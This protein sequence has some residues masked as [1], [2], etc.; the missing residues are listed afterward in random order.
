MTT[1]LR[2]QTPTNPRKP[3]TNFAPTELA[4]LK[5]TLLA[6]LASN[7]GVLDLSF[8]LE[9]EYLQFSQ[10]HAPNA[11]GQV[12]FR[13]LNDVWDVLEGE[14]RVK[15]VMISA[16]SPI[17]TQF[18]SVLV[19]PEIDPLSDER[20]GR[21]RTGM[22]LEW[23]VEEEETAIDVVRAEGRGKKNGKIAKAGHKGDISRVADGEP[24]PGPIESPLAVATVQKRT[25]HNK[26]KRK[27]ENPLPV[28]GTLSSLFSDLISSRYRLPKETSASPL[29]GPRRSTDLASRSSHSNIPPPQTPFMVPPL[30][31]VPRPKAQLP[32]PPL[33]SLRK[34]NKRRAK[35]PRDV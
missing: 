3:I 5:S 19:L 25:V 10:K 28:N 4:T 11:P 13:V 15:R 24:V 2:F 29:Q 27:S 16:M 21:L 14:G 31:S 20:V 7:G 17:G 23:G 9:N 6:L 22:A 35:I 12:D 26:R 18:K 30:S 8:R 1:Q 34:K 33:G 32:P